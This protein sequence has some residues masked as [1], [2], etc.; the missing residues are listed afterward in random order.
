M[1]VM[2][3]PVPDIC[4]PETLAMTLN[5]NM[6]CYLSTCV[7]SATCL[8]ETL[9]LTLNPNVKCY[10]STCVWSCYLST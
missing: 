3:N 9:A 6:E 4:L 7:W 10:L 1:L 2:L 5:P 8:P